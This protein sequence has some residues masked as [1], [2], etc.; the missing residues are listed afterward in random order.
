MRPRRWT[1]PSPGGCFSTTVK[2]LMLKWGQMG[3]VKEV[4]ALEFM[5]GMACVNK[6][7]SGRGKLQVHWGQAMSVSWG[8]KQPSVWDREGRWSA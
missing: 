2:T 8:Q 6:E 5:A 7:L 4:V 1:L 3:E